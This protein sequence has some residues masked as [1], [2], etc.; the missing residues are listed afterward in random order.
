MSIARSAG[1]VASILAL[2]VAPRALEAQQPAP[3]RVPTSVLERYVGE[4]VY[5]DGVSFRVVRSGDTLYREL[6]GQRIA[7]APLSETMFMFGPL[8]TAEFVLDAAGGATQIISN[9]KSIEFR[10]TRKGS[11]PAAIPPP[12]AAPAVRVSR[13]VLERYVGTYEYVA[14]QMS[15]TDLRIR[16]S[17]EGETLIRDGGGPRVKLTPMS[18]TLFR[19]GDTPFVVE[20]VVDDAGVTQIMGTG[21]QQALARLTSK[22]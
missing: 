18:Q 8:F 19:V 14:G 1:I 22:S 17:L 7:Y 2:T 20:F 4:W 21:F 10:L 13:E 16:V 3:V 11:P 5:P 9:G 15:R 6:S 12:P